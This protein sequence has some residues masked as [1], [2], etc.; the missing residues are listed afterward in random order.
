VRNAD[1]IRSR[2]RVESLERR[3]LLAAP[4][5]I[6]TPV[7]AD[8]W[9]DPVGGDD[10]RNGATRD[11]ALRTVTEAWNRIPIRESLPSTGYRINLV[12]GNYPE[13]TVPVYWESRYGTFEHPIVLRAADGAGT[14]RLPALNIFDTRFMYL[15]GLDVRAGGSDVLH[16]ELCDH[17]LIR[18]TSVTGAEP[19]SFAVQETVKINQSRFVFIES[20][21]ISGAFDNAI[22]FVAVQDGHV[23]DSRIHNSGDWCH[24]AKG[25][26][27]NLL[28][29]GNEYFDCGTGGFTAGQGTGFQ[30]MVSPWLH[31]EAYDLKFTNNLIHDVDGAAFGV[32]G[33]YN[34]LMA[35]NT[36][37]RVG[38]RSHL[39]EAVFGSRSCD[40][41]PGDDG[42]ERCSQYLADGGWGTTVVDDGN[43]G[44]RIPNRNVYV[45]NN[46]FYNPPGVQSGFQH[47]TIFGPYS[48]DTQSGSNVA[49][50]TLA[51]TNLQIRGNI[52]WDGP[53]DYPL[54]IEGDSDGCQVSNPA[55]NAEQIRR[56]NAI[57]TIEPQLVDAARG[58]FRPAPGGNVLTATTFA[59]PDFG[60]GDAPTR[61]AVPVGN[62]SNLVP[63]DRAGDPRGATSPPGAFAGTSPI[64]TPGGIRGRTFMD[65][66]GNGRLDGT[67]R[68]LAAGW[69]VFLDTN[70]NGSLDVGEPRQLTVT[71]GRYEFT[72]VAA[73]AVSVGLVPRTGFLTR[74]AATTVASGVIS[75]GVDLTAFRPATI[76]G[77]VFDDNN[78]NGIRNS[79][80][81]GLAG[82]RVYLDLNEDGDFDAGS[83]P[84]ALTNSRGRYTLANLAPG[85]YRVAVDLPAGRV[86]T[87]PA[88]AASAR[89]TVLSR[90]SAT[91]RFGVDET[92]PGGSAAWTGREVAVRADV[93]DHLFE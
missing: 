4:Y 48:G 38:T 32:N 54:G 80:E 57:N 19:E 61:P 9:V 3:Q 23:I 77:L 56:D 84:A 86:Q 30:F 27:A 13:S 31:Y 51:D 75:D 79:G 81:V 7:L 76:S 63:T 66:D 14:A 11:S 17:F 5:D 36:A 10:A 70:A 92:A 22:D 85:T 28:V 88:D 42:R 16:C 78:R 33:G 41:Q 67:D 6:G 58:D 37:Y 65:R 46:I 71:G 44:V 2:F 59:I 20:S 83:E 47:F 64:P 21:D 89:R 72:G 43:N 91:V 50:P 26:S 35:Y 52:I 39:F 49:V 69:T 93:L 34:I 74:G 60:G 90:G 82:V 24:Y 15:D 73:G 8:L 53:A 1:Q 62:S 55:C 18:N 12:A 25:G 40:G 45:Y 87:A 29:D 68:P